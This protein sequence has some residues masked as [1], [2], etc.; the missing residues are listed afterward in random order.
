MGPMRGFRL[1]LRRRTYAIRAGSGF[2][3]Y[4]LGSKQHALMSLLRPF[5]LPG[6]WG[7][8]AV[9]G[10]WVAVT[11]LL[12][13]ADTAPA[14]AAAL[15]AAIVAGMWVGAAAAGFVRERRRATREAPPPPPE[16]GGDAGV[17]EPRRPPPDPGI[18][19][20]ERELPPEPADA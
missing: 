15:A 10:G 4:V 5:D 17:R 8:V 2:E 9:V 19:V 18:V 1:R 12:R 7:L 3:G 6:R 16:G 14:T 20:A 13:V 11:A